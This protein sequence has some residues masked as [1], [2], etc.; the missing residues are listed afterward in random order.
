MS[1]YC[2]FFLLRG[3]LR[4]HIDGYGFG[5]GCIGLTNND[6]VTV[7]ISYLS[8]RVCF[9]S[10]HAFMLPKDLF[11]C[12]LG[13]ESTAYSRCSRIPLGVSLQTLRSIITARTRFLLSTYTTASVKYKNADTSLFDSSH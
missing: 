6:S 13:D 5:F 9:F 7:Y 1:F 11:E 4:S 2:T 8:D 3:V 10:M 12:H